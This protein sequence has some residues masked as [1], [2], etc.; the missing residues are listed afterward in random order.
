M[1]F[2]ESLEVCASEDFFLFGG[3]VGKIFRIKC[4]NDKFILDGLPFLYYIL[5]SQVSLIGQV[6]Q[7]FNNF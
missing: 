3:V 2:F 5:I 6:G 1:F 4:G 7:Y